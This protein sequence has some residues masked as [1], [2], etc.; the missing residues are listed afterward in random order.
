[1]SYDPVQP[2][3][4]FIEPYQGVI[5]ALQPQVDAIAN[6]MAPFQ[7]MSS[8]TAGLFAESNYFE[9]TRSMVDQLAGPPLRIEGAW[10]ALADMIGSS[11]PP[12]VGNVAEMLPA[13]G[14]ADL[15][16]REL[17]SITKIFDGHLRAFDMPNVNVIGTLALDAMP[18]FDFAGVGHRL[19]DVEPDV[20]PFITDELLEMEFPEE[21]DEGGA[22]A[23]TRRLTAREWRII[24]TSVGS[25]L[26]SD[27]FYQGK[28]EAWIDESQYGQDIA[29]W[30]AGLALV[31]AL[32]V[33]YGYSKLV[34][35]RTE[36]E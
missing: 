34:E 25:F 17:S 27:S 26:A 1:M 20:E 14:L 18:R 4:A 3:S 30:S 7:G 32:L 22:V 35:P 24:A 11:Q 23:R 9:A 29:L 36:D 16:D 5:A 31:T 21:V 15:F 10:S 8:I 28:L 2:L 19:L 33:V 13:L 6:A 12:I